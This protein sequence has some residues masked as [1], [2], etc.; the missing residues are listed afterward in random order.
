MIYPF[1]DKDTKEKFVF[2]PGSADSPAAQA[3]LSK[4]FDTD[5]LEEV[6]RPS[7]LADQLAP[8]PPAFFPFAP[9]FA[10]HFCVSPQRRFHVSL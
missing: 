9:A 4:T 10:H 8:E 3:I 2:V 1:I 7:S 6:R 5:E